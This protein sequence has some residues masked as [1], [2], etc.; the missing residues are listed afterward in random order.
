MLSY[1]AS[2]AVVTTRSGSRSKERRCLEI[3]HADAV[4]ELLRHSLGLDPW[5]S[6]RFEGPRL[7]AVISILSDHTVFLRRAAALEAGC[8]DGRPPSEGDW[9]RGLY[10]RAL[11]RDP[12]F[13][14]CGA[15]A[16]EARRVLEAGE[17]LAYDG[18]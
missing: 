5:G 8:R 10:E 3:E 16:R 1:Q 11:A 7:E 13:A 15:L 12:S 18:G 6:A 2:F 4:V 14:T 17:V 9:R